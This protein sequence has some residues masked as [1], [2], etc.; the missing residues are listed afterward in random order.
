MRWRK[1]EPICHG[2]FHIPLSATHS[3]VSWNIQLAVDQQA[4]PAWQSV[5]SRD[6]RECSVSVS[7]QADW[8]YNTSTFLSGDETKKVSLL[9]RCKIRQQITFQ[10]KFQICRIFLIWWLKGNFIILTRLS[11]QFISEETDFY[12]LS[13]AVLKRL[14]CASGRLRFSSEVSRC[15]KCVHGYLTSSNCL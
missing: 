7:S 5:V 11:L 15:E 14:T 3:Q 8:S 4:L 12:S 10:F 6:C 13:R 2:H 9:V 1:L